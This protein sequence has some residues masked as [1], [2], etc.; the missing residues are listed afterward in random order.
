MSDTERPAPR[1][2]RREP[3]PEKKPI[4]WQHLISGALASISI[5]GATVTS[6]RTGAAKE[7]AEQAQTAE[8]VTKESVEKY[9]IML[10]EVETM[11]QANTRHIDELEKRIAALE[12][13]RTNHPL[14]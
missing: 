5:I 10:Q 8:Y 2:A 1:R 12:G 3:E 9:R 7:S 14:R 4:N 6:V 13:G 11:R